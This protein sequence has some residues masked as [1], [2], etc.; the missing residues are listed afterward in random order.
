MSND[1]SIFNNRNAVGVR[2]EQRLTKLGQTLASSSTSRRIQCNIN[3]TFKKLVNGEQIGNSVRG[4]INVIII[5][6][7]PKVSRVY[8]A[9]KYDPNA[10]ATMP[11]CWSNAGDVPEASA[12][13]K[14]HDNCAECPMNI[15]GSGDNGGR[16]C[17]FQRRV[18]VL[19]EGDTT[20]DIYQMSIP[21]KSLFGKGSGNVHPF[22][23][24]VKFL[25]AN[26]ESPDTVVTTV[27][28][29]DE[30]EGMELVFSPSRQVEDV[31]F[32]LVQK[33][34]ARP[35][36]EMYTRI[37]VAQVDGATKEPKPR[38]EAQPE[39]KPEPKA[40][41]QRSDDPDDAVEEPKRRAGRKPTE[42]A[43]VTPAPKADLAAAIAEWSDD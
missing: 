9:G 23:G 8:Y 4:T 10:E 25:V 11:N 2:S 18:S 1:V 36:A 12:T 29:D 17:R 15:K 38:A 19:L 33:A 27:A 31:E 20:G 13:D 30:V 28:F 21:S 39:P 32:A 40:K 3:G 35:E 43:P 37:T 22:E 5:A 34:Q 41:V 14:Q 42:E 24:Y 26:G 7:Q 16:A 6:A